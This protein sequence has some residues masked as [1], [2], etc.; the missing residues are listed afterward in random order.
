MINLQL[1][2]RATAKVLGKTLKVIGT[3][4][5]LLTFIQFISN[6]TYIYARDLKTTGNDSGSSS[7]FNVIDFGAKGDGVTINTNDIQNAIDQCAVSGG[8]VLFPAGKFLTGSLVLKSNVEIYLSNGA[9]ILGSTN[10]KDYQPHTPSIKSYNDLF[11]K[12]SLFYAENANNISIEGNGI[13]DGQGSA[14]KVTTK[15]KP[16]RYENRPFIIRFIK[17]S[18]VKVEGITMRNSAM[19]M[20]HYLGC[21]YLTIKGVKIFNHANQNNDMMDIDGCSNVLI[22]DCFG[23]TD[24]D[25]ITLKSTSPIIDKNIIISNCI[26]SSHNNAVKIG[27]ESTGGFKNITI[28][29]IVIK[30]STVKSVIFGRPNGICGIAL[31]VVDGGTMDGINISGITMDSVEVPLFIRLGNRARKYS[32]NIPVPGV[33]VVKNI[34]I[35]NVV[36]TGV[37][38]TG[39]SIT[40]IPDHNVENISLN[41]IRIVFSGGGKFKDSEKIIPELQT[42]YPESTMWGRL[43]AYGFFIRHADDISF[44]NIRI[45]YTSKDVRPAFVCDNVRGLKFFDVIAECD[46][47][48][49]ALFEFKNVNDTWVRS[50]GSLSNIS[51]FINIEGTRSSN[52]KLIGNDF[53]NVKS[54]Y[55]GKEN[56]SIIL[57]GNIK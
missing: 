51:Q 47:S 34:S 19:W 31:E 29:N 35:N 13:I 56:K 41:N 1:I 8:K 16:Y 22:T 15:K 5:V 48:A 44:N 21:S 57:E 17:C 10:I 9:K 6:R 38:S 33:G 40:G 11:L 37:G 4:L 52:I 55:G 50:S 32:Q 20:Q 49:K 46:Q 18:N 2:N 53:T 7:V 28:S 14:F 36:A 24:D 39:C 25:G 27:T 26:V 30:P 12:Y 3:I 42:H 43:P 54:I 45:N 23:D